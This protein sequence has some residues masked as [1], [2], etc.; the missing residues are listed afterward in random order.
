MKIRLWS[1][2]HCEFGLFEFVERYDDKDSTL[3]IAGDFDVGCTDKTQ[4]LLEELCGK[5][6]AVVFVCGNHEYY[7]NEVYAVDMLYRQLADRVE[8]FY[9]LQGDYAIIDDVRFIGGTFWTDFNNDDYSVK[10][11]CRSRMNDYRT[12]KIDDVY[13]GVREFSPTDAFLINQKQREKFQEFLRQPFEGTTVIVT[14]HAPLGLCI[15]PSYN[16]HSSD[17]ILNFAYRN[18]GLEKWF[19]DYNFSHWLHGH[20]HRRQKHYVLDK[21]IVSNPRGYKNY[22][23][24]SFTWDN[25]EVFE[26]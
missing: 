3:V 22:E 20:I 12:I 4:E 24:I 18:T 17:Q 16:H 2:V 15:D 10:A 14:H 11:F 9:F 5:F 26:V 7:H 19:E 1:D 23:A 6:K 21:V 25:A 13:D 8:N